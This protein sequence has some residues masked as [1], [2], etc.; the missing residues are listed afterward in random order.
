M[1]C[2]LEQF[3]VVVRPV[4]LFLWLG[5]PMGPLPW[6]RPRLRSG[7]L[8]QRFLSFVVQLVPMRLHPLVGLMV[9]RAL[10]WRV[11]MRGFRHPLFAATPPVLAGLVSDLLL[12]SHVPE[13]IHRGPRL[14]ARE[15]LAHMLV[16]SPPVER[17][18]SLVI[19]PLVA[20]LSCVVPLW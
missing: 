14:L 20:T 19:A 8:R 12:R 9:R 4:P 3:Q 2:E 7:R 15:L 13:L 10:E 5:S 18:L 1:G 16:R 6:A 17:R 11:S